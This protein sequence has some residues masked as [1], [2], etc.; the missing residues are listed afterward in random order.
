MKL[1]VSGKNIDIGEALRTQVETR[2]NSIVDK[3]LE[4]RCTAAQTTF[5]KEGNNFTADCFLQLPESTTLES[6][7]RHQDAHVAFDTALEHLEARLRRHRGR[8]KRKQ[9]A[10]RETL[11]ARTTVYESPSEEVMPEE[12]HPAVILE[13]STALE[14]F[15]VPEAVAEFDL[16][17]TD[18]FVF[19]H[20]GTGRVNFLYRRKDGAIGWIDTPAS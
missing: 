13:T 9:T 2:I 7:G 4:G 20:S 8:L 1:R 6:T 16:T 18:N 12:Y 10:P 5:S 14:R 15:S 11:K 19:I 3:Y 17:G